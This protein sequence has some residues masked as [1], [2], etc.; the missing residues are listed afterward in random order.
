MY[1]TRVALARAGNTGETTYRRCMLAPEIVGRI[2]GHCPAMKSY[3]IDRLNGICRIL[4]DRL[5]SKGWTVAQEPTIKDADGGTFIPNIV[6]VVIDPTIIYE[7]SDNSLQRANLG[8]VQKY[9]PLKDKIKILYGLTIDA[10]DGWCSNNTKY[11]TSVGLHDTGFF[12]LSF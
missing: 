11:L 7:N 3:W 6:A 1:P 12:I 10:C 8:K 5:K 2:S 4:S 9:T